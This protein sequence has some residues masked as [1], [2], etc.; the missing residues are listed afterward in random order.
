MSLPLLMFGDGCLWLGSIYRLWVHLALHFNIFPV[1]WEDSKGSVH[2]I[3]PSIALAAL[4][5]SYQGAHFYEHTSH[6][7]STEGFPGGSVVKN[8]PA[9]AGEVGSILGS[10]RFPWRGKWHPALVCFPR[11][12]ARRSLVDYSP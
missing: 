7:E 5:S 1:S 8:P 9:S 2:K 11:H 4:V 3:C 10:G 12:R 6:C